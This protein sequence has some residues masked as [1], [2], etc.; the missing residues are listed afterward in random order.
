MLSVCAVKLAILP[1]IGVFMVQAMAKGG[2]IPKDAK[3]ELFVAMFFSGT[4]AAVK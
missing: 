4:P 1:V 3:V 2:L